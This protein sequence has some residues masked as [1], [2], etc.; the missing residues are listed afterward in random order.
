MTI[1]GD[2]EIAEGFQELLRA[3]RPDLE[4]ELSRQIGDVAAH[5]VGNLT[6]WRQRVGTQC[7]GDFCGQ[8]RRVSARKKAATW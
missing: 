4:E 6:T 3:A 2:A 5:Q 7:C 8:R 1:N